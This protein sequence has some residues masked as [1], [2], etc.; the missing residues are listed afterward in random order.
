[1]HICGFGLGIGLGLRLVK[2]VWLR[3][4][5]G[6]LFESRVWVRIMPR[7]EFGRFGNHI[8]VDVH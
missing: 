8:F 4:V 2:G 3:L 7:A 5:K 6:V 1:M